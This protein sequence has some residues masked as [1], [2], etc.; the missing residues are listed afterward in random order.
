MFDAPNASRTYEVHRATGSW[1]EATVTWNNQPSVVGAATDSASSG[2][3]N[4]VTLSWDVTSDVQLFVSG[5]ASNFGWRL[6][7]AQE[8]SSS[9]REA[10]FRSSEAS[11][12]TAR[13]KL[14][15]TYTVQ[16]SLLPGQQPSIRTV[17]LTSSGQVLQEYA[18]LLA[19]QP[20]T[21]TSGPEG[22]QQILL[23]ALSPIL[24]VSY[25]VSSE[26]LVV[27]GRVDKIK[28]QWRGRA[29]T[30]NV[31][32]R[33][34]VQESTTGFPSKP[35]AIF[36]LGTQDQTFT[37]T[38]SPQAKDFALSQGRVTIKVE[39]TQSIAFDLLTDFIVFVVFD[40]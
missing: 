38:L 27:P 20:R 12:S 22:Q 13:P 6:S 18:G 9:S 31:T 24:T 33:L 35:S 40:P 2:T 15:V 8:G 37:F 5:Q 28:V 3:Q 25:T 19:V 23:Q 32:L 16:Q 26:T 29:S 1:S 34:F 14:V 21:T 11:Q 39:A 7:D 36:T 17:A 30:S 10:R 4:N